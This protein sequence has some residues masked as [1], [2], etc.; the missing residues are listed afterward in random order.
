MSTAISTFE[1]IVDF[2]ESMLS[3]ISS[4]KTQL[5]DFQR[6]WVWD[7]NN[8]KSL[9]ASISLSFPVGTV[10]FL[11]TGND[12]VKFKPRLVEGVSLTNG[13][14]PNNLIL[15]G[16]QRLTSLYQALASGTVV[17]T[18]DTRKKKIKRWYYIDMVKA[19][20]PNVDREDAIV[21]L[22]ESKQIKNFRGKITSDY[23]TPQLEYESLLFPLQNV[24][25]PSS[26]RNSF[27]KHWEYQADKIQL[28]DE[29]E[30]EI[31]ERFKKYQLPIIRLLKPTPKEAV[32]LVFEKVNTGGVSL[33]VFEL[34]TANFAADNFDLR[35]DW[36]KRDKALRH[37][38]T[39]KALAKLQSD[40]FLQAISLLVT[41][42]K[43]Q[44]ALDSG[45]LQDKAPGV[46]CKRKDIL[47]LT[48]IDYQEWAD[49]VTKGFEKVAS[50]MWTQKIFNARDVPYRTQLVPLA[51]VYALLGD[52]AE[53]DHVRSKLVQ[54]YWCGVF[55]ELYGSAVESRFARDLVEI[56]D[57]I[58]GGNEPSTVRDANFIPNRL[59]T[60]KTRNSAAYKGLSALL[61]RDG[62]HDFI[63]GEPIDVNMYAEARVDIHHIFP[64]DWCIKHDI[65][66]N[67]RDCIVNKTPLTYRTNR[68]IGKNAPSI[69]LSRVENDGMSSERMDEILQSHVINSDA[70]RNDEFETYF[71]TR[72]QALLQRIELAMGKAVI[73]DVADDYDSPDQFELEEELPDW[74]ES[75]LV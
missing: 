35:E 62:G 4:G 37:N 34:L 31:I 45:T 7:D 11:E 30:S 10:M 46:S 48:H 43:R 59:Y 40:D 68:R 69:Y 24:F 18:H 50:L 57:W 64:K 67:R 47:N 5:P 42:T 3:D 1:S 26:W 71:E 51:T 52:D 58:N 66:V 6:G 70:I 72:K 29:F 22:P 60:L 75:E 23:S 12:A 73:T 74:L 9:L 54:W 20:D 63:T 33:T 13:K 53:K 21:S 16:Q 41:Y 38:K 27:H 44:R 8:I 32:C 15:D 56:V 2:L 65:E 19:L 28:L 61:L 25:N 55:G 14:E 17:E 49:K 36:S 39:N